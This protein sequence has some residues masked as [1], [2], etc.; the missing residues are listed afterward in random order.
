MSDLRQKLCRAWIA[1]PDIDE[2]LQQLKLCDDGTGSVISGGGQA[3]FLDSDLNWTLLSEHRIRIEFRSTKREHWGGYSVN[4]ACPSLVLG[5]EL[6]EGRFEF[7]VPGHGRSIIFGQHLRLSESPLPQ[8][9]ASYHANSLFFSVVNRIDPRQFLDYYSGPHYQFDSEPEAG[10][11]DG[12]AELATTSLVRVAMIRAKLR[13]TWRFRVVGVDRVGFHLEVVVRLGPGKGPEHVRFL[14]PGLDVVRAELI[15]SDD[16]WV[17]KVAGVSAGAIVSNV[18]PV[19]LCQA[20]GMVFA[21]APRWN[22]G[23]TRWF[24]EPGAVIAQ[25]RFPIPDAPQ[26]WELELSEALNAKERLLV[27]ASGLLQAMSAW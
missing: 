10:E 26:F 14:E 12:Y 15:R 2:L 5:F 1:R 6:H 11:R 20:N 8:D 24:D 18:T 25:V 21:R 27:I 3:I 19:Q 9:A 16:R 4:P 13:D 22:S 17:M 7:H 23:E